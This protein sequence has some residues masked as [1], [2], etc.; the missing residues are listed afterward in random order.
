MRIGDVTLMRGRWSSTG[1]LSQD[2]P[3][4]HFGLGDATVVDELEIRW[5]RGLVETFQNVP[6]DRTVY[7]VE[8]QGFDV[9][10][11][12]VTGDVQPDGLF[13]Q[14]SVAGGQPFDRFLVSRSAEGSTAGVIA[15]LAP[16][17]T[18]Y[19]DTDVEPGVTY[20]YRIIGEIGEQRVESATLVLSVPAPIARL[21]VTPAKPNPFNPG[22]TIEFSVPADARAVRVALVDARGRIVRSFEAPERGVPQS[23]LWDGTDA[24]GRPVASGSYRF[25]VEADGEV[26]S[27]ALTLVR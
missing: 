24:Q 25:V 19:V 3:I 20:T 15:E 10:S 2:A 16:D 22:T 11:P 1:Y 9:P 18:S 26:V 17:V 13:L 27:T 23:V 4:V 7:L 6:V 5:P 12:I 8:G 21:V 14:W